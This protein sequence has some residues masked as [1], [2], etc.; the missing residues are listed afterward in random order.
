MPINILKGLLLIAILG[1][2]GLRHTS[3]S[4]QGV[5]EAERLLQKAMQKETVDGDLRAAI[6]QYKQILTRRDAGRT[7]VARALF[8][9]GRCQEKLGNA[10]A[11]KSYEQLVR[12]YADQADIASEARA[13]LAAMAKAAAS[14]TAPTVRQVWADSRVETTGAVSP[15]GRFLSFADYDGGGADLFVREMASG[16]VRRVTNHKDSVLEHWQSSAFSPDGKQ[17]AYVCQNGWQF[18]LRIIGIDG[19]NPRVLLGKEY[20]KEDLGYPDIS[21]GA[22]AADGK[23]VAVSLSPRDRPWQIAL[24]SVAD[25]SVRV[26]RTLD[27][28]GPG[29]V[30]L[31]PDGR[32]VAYDF[33]QKEEGKERDIFILPTDGSREIRLVLH[34]ATDRTIGWTPDG[35]GLLFASDRTGTMDLWLI[36]VDQGKPQG[37]PLLV[38]KEGGN[39]IPLG[40]TREGS[41]YY[42]LSVGTEE[43]YVATLDAAAGRIVSPPVALSRRYTG[44]SLAPDWSPDGRYLAFASRRIPAVSGASG[45][46]ITIR[47]VETGEERELLS[48]IDPRYNLR[49]SPDGRTLL[50]VGVGPENQSGAYA[51]NAQTGD[52]VASIPWAYWIEWSRDGKSIYYLHNDPNKARVLIRD[53]QTGQDTVLSNDPMRPMA[54][55]PDGRWLAFSTSSGAHAYTLNVMPVSGGNARELLRVQQAGDLWSIAWAPD[56]RQLFFVKRYVSENRAE[57]W[58]IAVEGGEP[59]NLGV[60]VNTISQISIHPDGRRIAYNYGATNSEIWVME[61]FLPSRKPER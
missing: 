15:D 51:I 57:L 54:V 61:N 28:R 59:Q 16:K 58:R 12:D 46:V 39:I 11:R 44:G 26:L 42:A 60:A 2:G 5:T 36:Q 34:P 33:P 1:A 8:Q 56:G 49:W 32:Y 27:R 20:W 40:I 21:P 50:V 35:T 19:S 22:W 17:I 24:V 48:R 41:F 3:Y 13:R 25:G 53:F 37:P 7:V 52:V 45:R 29:Y 23:H 55:S 14:G 6:E 31:S 43:I 38:K 18:E 9:L 10:E 47:T 4:P 30:S